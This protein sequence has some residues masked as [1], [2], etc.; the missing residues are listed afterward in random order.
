M[1]VS[2]RSALRNGGKSRAAEAKKVLTGGIL[3]DT[4]QSRGSRDN[5]EKGE[6]TKSLSPIDFCGDPDA[7]RKP[8]PIADYKATKAKSHEPSL[9]VTKL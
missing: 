5:A 4:C 8:G 9:R 2:W 1:S 6:S 7:A 3:R